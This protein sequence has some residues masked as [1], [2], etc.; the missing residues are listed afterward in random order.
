MTERIISAYT[1][2]VPSL[3]QGTALTSQWGF[4]EASVNFSG[5]IPEGSVLYVRF[6][7]SNNRWSPACTVVYKFPLKNRGAK[8]VAAEYIINTDP[9]NGNATPVPVGANGLMQLNGLAMNR[10]DHCYVCVKDS[11]GK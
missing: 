10:N 2:S 9:G 7:S 8:L 11:F 6:K 3:G 4:S 5:T 1:L